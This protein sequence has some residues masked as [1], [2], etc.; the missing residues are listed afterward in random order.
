MDVY[1]VATCSG[2]DTTVVISND[3]GSNRKA[4]SL[5]DLTRLKVAGVD[6]ASLERTVSLNFKSE[7]SASA[8][9]RQLTNQAV[10]VTFVLNNNS[11]EKYDKIRFNLN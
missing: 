11:I 9:S 6:D 7:T 8:A 5:D 2:S 10:Q 3:A 4:S 1:G